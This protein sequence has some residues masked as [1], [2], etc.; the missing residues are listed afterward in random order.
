MGSGALSSAGAP[1]RGVS[2]GRGP[3]ERSHACKTVELGHQQLGRVRR[4][5]GHRDAAG[6][7]DG[8][9][10][11]RRAGRVCLCGRQPGPPG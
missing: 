1:P 6:G 8:G 7:R 3:A 10:W 2:P 5:G 9:G 11:R 4:G